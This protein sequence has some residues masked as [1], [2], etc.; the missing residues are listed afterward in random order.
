LIFPVSQFFERKMKN[1]SQQNFSQPCPQLGVYDDPRTSFDYPSLENMCF[2]CRKPA[3]PLLTH[4]GEFCLTSANETCPVHELPS[5]QPF[6]LML[7]MV[8][9]AHSFSIRQFLLFIVLVFGVAFWAWVGWESLFQPKHT[10]NSLVLSTI[11]NKVPVMPSEIPLP[12]RT[13]TFVLP[14]PTLIFEPTLTET[15]KTAVRKLDV[16]FKI[17]DN[18]FVIHRILA[19]ETIEQVAIKFS[20]STESIEKINFLPVTSLWVDRLILIMLE[21]EVVGPALPAFEPYQ[22][23]DPEISLVDLAKRFEI[24]PYQLKYYNVCRNPCLFFVGDWLII[25]R[26]R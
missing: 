24:E 11:A 17:G 19:G 8:Y 18:Y 20:T 15:K 10:Q 2:H 14:S 22:V 21:T 4:Q 6:P 1:S 16:P 25:P 3:T 9:K 5:N 23:P 26:S 13:K 12:P 7:R